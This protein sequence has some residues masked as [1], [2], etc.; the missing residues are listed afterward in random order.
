MSLAGGI[1][2]I[3]LLNHYGDEILERLRGIAFTDSVHSLGRRTLVSS[4]KT[5]L[6]K[7]GCNWVQSKSKLDTLI[8][9]KSESQGCKCVSAGVNIHEHT[10]EACRTSAFPFLAKCIKG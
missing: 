2:T 3:N 9:K 10:S 6:E 8:E 1:V 7:K 4:V 5:F